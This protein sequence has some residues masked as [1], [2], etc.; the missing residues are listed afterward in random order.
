M[1]HDLSG[2][3]DDVHDLYDEA[4]LCTSTGAYTSAVLTCRKILMHVAVEKGA[5]EG[6]NFFIM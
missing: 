5:S 6:E 3:P 1:G 2:L 4:R